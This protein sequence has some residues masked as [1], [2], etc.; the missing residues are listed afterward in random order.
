MHSIVGPCAG[1]PFTNIFSED[2]KFGKNSSISQYSVPSCT[3]FCS[4]QLGTLARGRFPAFLDGNLGPLGPQ[5]GSFG[6]DVGPAPICV[7]TIWRPCSSSCTSSYTFRFWSADTA[8]VPV[9]IN[10]TEYLLNS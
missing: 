2:D 8:S 6:S 5:L 1:G 3:N 10:L 7:G 4:V 9:F